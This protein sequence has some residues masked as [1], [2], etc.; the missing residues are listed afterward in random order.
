KAVP[1]IGGSGRVARLSAPVDY[2]NGLGL[3]LDFGVPLALWLAARRDHPHW[4]RAGGV[5]FLYGLVV[6][7]LLTASRAGIAVGVVTAAVWLVLGR[8]RI[9]AAA[10]LL[11]GG[12]VGLGVG[13]WALSRSGL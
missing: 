8:P 5:V 1:A 6:G 11:L 3:L 13:V 12:S 4:L 2:W 7:L 9:E 10:G